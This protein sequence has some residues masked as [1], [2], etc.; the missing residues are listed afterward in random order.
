MIVVCSTCQARFKVADDKIGPR[1]AKVRCSKCQTV[2]IVHRELG[3]MP[4][5]EPAA[6]SPPAAPAPSRGMELDLEGTARTGVRPS[7]FV[8]D[9]FSRP[10]GAPAAGPFA[11]GA[12]DPFAGAAPGHA[13]PPD[14]FASGDPFRPQSPSAP[15]P[16]DPFGAADPFAASPAS[17]GGGLGSVDPFVA[18]VA[19]PAPGLPTSAVTDLSDLLGGGGGAARPSSPVD[20]PAPPPEPSGILETGFDFDTSASPPPELDTGPAPI[21]ATPH[22][23]GG[24]PEPDLALAERTPAHALPAAPMP[25]F[26][27]FA[28][29]D[30]FDDPGGGAPDSGLT[31]DHGDAFG[32]P[33]AE[34][35]PPPPVAPPREPSPAP[36]PAPAPAPGSAT[37]AEAPEAQVAVAGSPRRRSRIRSLAVNTVSLVA[38]LAVAMA[39]L[40]FWRGAR[41][42]SGWLRPGAFFGDA[43]EVLEPFAAAQVRSGLYERADAPPILFVAGTAISHAQGAV[44]GLRVRV[45][46]VRKGEVVA[47]G[48]GRAGLVPS[49]EELSGSRDA[50][51]IEAALGRRAD[52]L[53]R[54]VGPGEGV[55]FLVAISDYP[56]DVAGAGLRVHVEPVDGPSAP[57]SPPAGN[58][59]AP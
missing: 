30:P 32:H 17:G 39:F 5:G 2:F 56:P 1:G 9:P 19:A 6:A 47:R 8:A 45:E 50:A 35:A 12:P 29:M 31:L 55:P 58:P 7:G 34:V 20:A 49:P 59:P 53:P 43:G 36:A 4:A 15:A 16:P 24:A 52:A 42:G 46:V 14:P 38:L 51:G 44:A 33:D 23:A 28:G 41:P 57:P 48:E 18:T 21:P 27:D 54:A 3:V 40:A 22:A 26:G 37:G 11:A 13:A 10:P 25:G